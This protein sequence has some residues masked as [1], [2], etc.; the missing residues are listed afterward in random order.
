MAS[1]SER[2]CPDPPF[3]LELLE[4]GAS[5]STETVIA[6][7]IRPFDLSK[8][9]LLRVGLMEL[10]GDSQLLIF[11]MHHI[12]SDGTSL[13]ILIKEFVAL[14]QG[15][16][17]PELRIQYKDFAAWQNRQFTA[18]SFQ[19]QERYWL[20]RF[21]G[22]IPVLNLPLDYTR[23]SIQSIAGDKF[24]FEAGP[25]LAGR[26]NQLAL[27]NGATV[28]MVLLAIYNVLLAKYT[29]QDDIIAGSPIAG[30]QHSD[31]GNLIGM[32][33][34]TLAMR[35]YPGNSRVF[36]EFLAEV[37]ENVLKAFENQDYPFDQ[38]VEKL[39][40]ARELSRNPLFDTMFVF[41]NFETNLT[42]LGNLRMVPLE[43]A[44]KHT[45]FDI[46]LIVVP[47]TGRIRFYFEYCTQLFR[48]E[49]IARMAEHMLNL[50]DVVA[51]SPGIP[52]AAMEVLSAGERRKI[53][54]VFNT[55]GRDY[56][57][58]QKINE[59]FE[60]QVLKTPCRP[61]VIYQ[62]RQ[63]TYDEL[64]HK[65]NQMAH[66]LRMA[67][68]A[69]DDIVAIVAARSM[70]LI[71]AML[72]ILKAGGAYLPIDPDYPE[73]RIRYMLENSGA[74]L[75]LTQQASVHKVSPDIQ[76]LDLD[77]PGLYQGDAGNTANLGTPANL[78]YVIYTSGST[79]KPKGVMIEHRGIGNLQA[80]FKEYLRV[81]ENDR[82][83]QFAVSS[84]D[85]SVWEI[86][87]ALLTGASLYIV[88]KETI[89]NYLEFE[90]FLNEN[91][92]SIATLP[93]TY[94]AN[95]NPANVITLKKLIVAGS[96]ST[97]ELLHK[98][99]NKVEYINA[100]GPT[101]TTVCATAW[102]A[103]PG[104]E[105]YR[106][107]PIGTPIFNTR[108]Y[109]IN[110]D[111]RLQPMGVAGELCVAGDGLARGYLNQPELTAE[112]FIPN[113]FVTSVQ[114]RMYRTGDLARWLPDGNLEF[115][116][117]IDNQVKIRGFRIEI[118]EIENQLLKH[119]AV[120]E[121]AVIA[122]ADQNGN[123][124]LCAY[125][126]AGGEV[127]AA[128]LKGF[129]AREL[130]E[131]MIPAYFIQLKSLPLTPN[132]KV[133]HHA[134]PD[135]AETGA[136]AA[137]YVPPRN[138]IER[139]LA[140][141]W[142][143]VL[144]R[145][146]IGIHN[147]FFELG[148]DS[149]KA[150]QL[151]TKLLPDFEINITHIFE[152]QT[153]AELARTVVWKKDYLKSKLEELKEMAIRKKPL[154][155]EIV[156]RL[157]SQ[158]NEY[159]RKYRARAR[160]SYAEK[161]LKTTNYKNIL[162]TGATGYLGSHILHELL[163]TTDSRI[164]VLVRG[165]SSQE[166]LQRLAS[167]TR[168]YFGDY[169]FEK[170]GNRIIV[171]NGDL[172][173][174]NLGLTKEMYDN[175][176]QIIECIIHAAAN[177][178][179]YGHYNDL[180]EV[181]VRGT[182]Q[183]VDFAIQSK[184][185]NF[186]YISTLSV[187]SGIPGNQNPVLFTEYHLPVAA[188]HENYYIKSKLEAEQIV[189]GAREQGLNTNIFRVGNLVFHSGSGRFQ[190]NIAENAFYLQLKSLIKLGV[191][192]K[193]K[194]PALEFSFIDEVSKAVVLLFRLEGPA[195]EIHHL[196][197]QKRISLLEF[198]GILKQLKLP[199]KMVDIREFLDFLERNYHNLEMSHFVKDLMIHS[200]LLET[201]DT[202]VVEISCAKTDYLLKKL[203]FKWSGFNKVS[204][205]KMINYCRE[206]NFL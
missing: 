184:M 203:G 106:T 82:I 46:T 116:G 172:T 30:R 154:N 179:H 140:V 67:G 4:A 78:A 166:A 20:E 145:P 103:V 68:I 135:P 173:K 2:I 161:G 123:H 174:D 128:E 109:I 204:A 11:D 194:Q 119:E 124:F 37:K 162:L 42:G 85:A 25:E 61:A 101:E 142:Q 195:N 192:P 127:M 63:L 43:L 65:S 89:N 157:L 136:D 33:V 60:A 110:R 90:T 55:T 35:N 197:N 181:N 164:Y 143:E 50:M 69:P 170:F 191:I 31:L 159:R 193:I 117:R 13:S 144:G 188:G 91:E 23:P 104:S 58:D 160:G 149:L 177:V 28:Y 21:A 126:T 150:I 59:L 76:T 34:N 94:L 133:N 186:S 27:E 8:A 83:I 95:L 41:Q 3:E 105:R 176:S 169:L 18:A 54:E 187:A 148:G 163:I 24:T 138:E 121:I 74:K 183:L 52:I 151:V 205:Q 165:D 118:G 146:Q 134:L 17:L 80:Y 168:L 175:L 99:Q 36:S 114:E 189:I 190:E 47:E 29:G 6:G 202:A 137:T 38:L 72:G 130:P 107:V 115:L 102:K 111:H 57:K 64:N 155:P 53:L 51:A 122:K 39:K 206:V 16:E 132:G 152:H 62:G 185:R 139:N 40:L 26:I 198:G 180:Y 49:T 44:S 100:Y 71:I 171:L 56:H 201:G 5:V 87:M 22:E 12:I 153:I 141:V 15:L 97:P 108:V 45:K 14:Y 93:P 178:K 96:A 10:T 92:I 9:P 182:K 158:Q 32:F 81:A 79:G 112:K 120:Q 113:P 48:R 88:P 199:V 1:R 200:N 196:A 129:L 77:D 66:G 19:N 70:E 75:I 86:F 167:K 131:Y 98:W 73:E 125:Y 84:F 156:T 147:N 7:F